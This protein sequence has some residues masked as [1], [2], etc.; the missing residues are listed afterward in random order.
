MVINLELVKVVISGLTPLS[1]FIA[2]M[3]YRSNVKKQRLDMEMAQDRE[4]FEQAVLSL[5]WAYDALTDEGRCVPPSADRLNWLTCARHLCRY[6]QIAEAI[7]TALYKTSLSEHEEYWRH[8]FYIAIDF[9]ELNMKDYYM[10]ERE[11]LWPENIE[12]TSASII[13]EFSSWKESAIDP[14]DSYEVE[15]V[16]NGVISRGLSSYKSVFDSLSK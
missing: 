2:Y 5:K 10:D 13:N 8:K 14:I 16:S 11:V 12:P 1:I 7:K 3:T 15:T 4:V 9:K 6:Y